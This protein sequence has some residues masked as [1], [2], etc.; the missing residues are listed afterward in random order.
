MNTKKIVLL[1]ASHAAA[2]IAGFALGIYVLPILIEPPPPGAAEFAAAVDQAQFKAKFDP[3]LKGSDAIHWGDGTVYIG[4][5]AIAL[6]GK[7]APGPDYKV[8][9]S[10]EFVDTR[11]E[12]LRVK[13]RMMRVG[14]VKTF[15]NFVVPVSESVDPAA[16]NTVAI[17]CERF[18]MFITAAKYR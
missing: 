11:A 12:F 13:P 6:K 15:Q 8:Y 14:D 7:V 2:L 3:D 5:K 9:L 18:Q 17:W 10:P 4:R 16:Y 1:V